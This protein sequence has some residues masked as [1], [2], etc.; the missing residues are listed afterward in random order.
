MVRRHA[1][2]FILPS[3]TPP[4]WNA[5][6]GQRLGGSARAGISYSVFVRTAPAEGALEI[7]PSL[8]VTEGCW[9]RQDVP[10]KL[11]SFQ[12]TPSH[13]LSLI[14]RGFTKQCDP[15]AAGNY[16][17]GVEGKKGTDLGRSWRRC[18]PDVPG[19]KTGG[20]V[21]CS[22]F[23]DEVLRCKG[24][25]FGGTCGGLRA[26]RMSLCVGHDS[27]PFAGMRK[28]HGIASRCM[29]ILARKSIP[30]GPESLSRRCSASD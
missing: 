13:P 16:R 24:V 5:T 20:W 1:V 4:A 3:P 22:T 12:A 11:P 14:S 25:C 8:L 10:S 29:D 6:S 18:G 28:G 30:R 19:G 15:V 7:S 21:V 17:T 9:F 2:S 23:H 27:M 26:G